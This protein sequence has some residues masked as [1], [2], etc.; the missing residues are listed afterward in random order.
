LRGVAGVQRLVLVGGQPRRGAV[1]VGD[2]HPLVVVG[3]VADAEVTLV[4][5]VKIDEVA[6]GAHGVSLPWIT[7]VTGITGYVFTVWSLAGRAGGLP[8]LRSRRRRGSASAVVRGQGQ[9]R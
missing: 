6:V 2:P 5:G 7:G 1:A 8:A 9:R 4:V 3:G